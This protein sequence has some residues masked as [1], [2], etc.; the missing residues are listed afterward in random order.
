MI[1]GITQPD[2]GCITSSMSD[3][4]L[5][6]YGFSSNFS[7]IV[8][9][10]S[11]LS[12]PIVCSTIGVPRHRAQ[13]PRSEPLFRPAPRSLPDS[14]RGLDSDRRRGSRT[15]H[16]R[17]TR[18]TRSPAVRSNFRRSSEAIAPLGGDRTGVLNT[19]ALFIRMIPFYSTGY[20]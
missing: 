15:F 3:D 14:R 2:G 20:R 6:H 10:S 17:A 16:Y 7:P 4:T 19:E 18:K 8:S 9:S 11:G 5:H 1:A 12:S 13:R